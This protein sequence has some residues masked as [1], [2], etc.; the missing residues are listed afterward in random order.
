MRRVF[1]L[2]SGCIVLILLVCLIC[3]CRL[4]CC[5]FRLVSYLFGWVCG[6]GYCVWIVLDGWFSVVLVEGFGCLWF[7]VSVV[8][9]VFVCGFDWL[10]CLCC[11]LLSVIFCVALIVCFGI[12]GFSVFADCCLLSL[13]LL[14]A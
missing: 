2:L 11:L 10:I 1:C 5:R 12:I 8:C 14:I 9:G 7:I 4:V 3:D 13:S 6:F